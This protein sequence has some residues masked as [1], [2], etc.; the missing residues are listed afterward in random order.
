MNCTSR[1]TQASVS[2]STRPRERELEGTADGSNYS[3]S[4]LFAAGRIYFFSR[5]AAPSSLN[6]AEFKQLAD[7][8]LDSGFML[9]Q[10]LPDTLCF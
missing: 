5:K 4:P 9:R 1:R 6:T 2:A 10:P 3:A 7:N 8:Q